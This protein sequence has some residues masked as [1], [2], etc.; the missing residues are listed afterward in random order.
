M[1]LRIFAALLPLLLWA[2]ADDPVIDASECSNGLT[3]EE[4]DQGWR[5]LF[6]G[7]SLAQWPQ[8]PGGRGQ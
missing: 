6:D 5:L 3:A 4:Q 7:Q 1:L 8:L 2:C